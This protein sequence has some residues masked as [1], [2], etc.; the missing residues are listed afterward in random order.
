MRIFRQAQVKNVAMRSFGWPFLTVCFAACCSQ[1]ADS[2]SL[3][4]ARTPGSP[5]TVLVELFTSEGCSS[6]PPADDI[7]SD[8]VQHQPIENV[9][10]IGMGEH[11]DYWNHLGWRDPFSSALFSARQSE[12]DARVFH[13]GTI[14]TPQFVADGRIQAVGGDRMAVRRAIADAARFEKADVSVRTD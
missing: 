5:A 14:Y 13:S 3:V 10:V 8:L 2:S 6:C 4:N 1:V 12:Y 7:L 11:V 9:T